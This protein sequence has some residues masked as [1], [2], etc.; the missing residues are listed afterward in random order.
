MVVVWRRADLAGAVGELDAS[1][2]GLTSIGIGAVGGVEAAGAFGECGELGPGVMESGD[3]A[4]EVVEMVFE[5]TSDVLA[6][7][8]PLFSQLEDGGDLGEG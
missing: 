1:G 3:V 2:D 8:R 7:E 4:V 6:R 5:E